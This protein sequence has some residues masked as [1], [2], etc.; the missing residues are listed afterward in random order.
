MRHKDAN[1]HLAKKCG[2]GFQKAI[3]RMSLYIFFN[4]EKHRRIKGSTGPCWCATRR[5]TCTSPR[6]AA[7]ASKKQLSFLSKAISRMSRF[8]CLTTKK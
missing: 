5:Q 2:T 1:L 6:G 4:R 3:S 8:V 7:L